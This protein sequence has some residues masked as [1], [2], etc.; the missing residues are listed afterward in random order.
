MLVLQIYRRGHLTRVLQIAADY[1]LI[2]MVL[3]A[4]PHLY[5]VLLELLPISSD[6][7]VSLVQKNGQLA[8]LAQNKHILVLIPPSFRVVDTLHSLCYFQILILLTI[9]NN[10]CS[11]LVLEQ[12]VLV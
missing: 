12:Q 8:L 9:T 11:L 3:Q 2:Q 1:V 4:F 6:N 10:S 7:N 5:H